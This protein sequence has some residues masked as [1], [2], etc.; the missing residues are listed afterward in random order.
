MKK[1]SVKYIVLLLVLCSTIFGCE[2]VAELFHGPKPEDPPVTYTVAFYANGAT[3]T[4]PEMQTVEIGTVISLPDKGDLVS[5][6]YIFVGWN[7]NSSGAGTT[8]SVGASITVD[9]NMSFY[10]QWFDSSTPQFTITF[11]ANGATGGSPPQSQTVYQGISITIPNQG[12]LVHTGRTFGGWNTLANGGGANYLTGATYTVNGD[13]IL[14]ARWQSQFQLTVVYH[15]NGAAGN[16]P[17]SQSYDSGTEF[18]LPN[19]G[20]MTYSG[21]RF[22]GWNT[23]A[24]GSG[25]SFAG[26]APVT[27]NPLT[28]NSILTLYA[29]WEVIPIVPQG[30]TIEEKISYISNASPANGVVYEIV[31]DANEYIGPQEIRTR[32]T[33]TTVIIRSVSSADIKYIQLTNTGMLFCTGDDVTL[34]MQN[35]EL[36][37]INNNTHPVVCLHSTNA[38]IIMESG[39]KITGNAN[40]SSLNSYL[41]YPG[42]GVYLSSGVFEMDDGAEISGNISRNNGG[43]IYVYSGTVNIRG[44]VINNNAAPDSNGGGIYNEYSGTINMIGGIISNNTAHRGGGI[45]LRSGTF[46]KRIASGRSGSGVI[47]GIGHP[48]ANTASIGY[49]H[50]IFYSINLDRRRNTTLGQTDEISTLT[51]AGWE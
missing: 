42:G 24:N 9:R 41:G 13:V 26:G 10:A 17:P 32:G 51:T 8:H 40:S 44:G 30:N 36:R 33:N 35:I 46:I 22:A 47:Y 29:Q 37:G 28:S 3:G 25:T 16:P 31:V 12:T 6:G 49:G 43:G 5:T 18:F 11:N 45:Y 2:A 15:A 38:K 50:A 7:I 20:D 19:E 4:P 27:V 39:V 14:Y 21:R 1:Q 48:D 34:R 23:Q